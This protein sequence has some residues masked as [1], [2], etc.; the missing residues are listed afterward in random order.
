MSEPVPKD[1]VSMLARVD[2]VCRRFEAAWKAHLAEPAGAPRPRL[3]YYVGQLPESDQVPLGCEL[4]A[5][6]A[7]YARRLAGETLPPDTGPGADAIMRVRYFGDYELL[8][9]IAS[10]GFG[11]VY[12]A[13]QVTLNRLVALKMIA[14]GRLATPELVQRFRLEA[15]AA[16]GLEHEGIVP[17]YEVGA[18]D[19]QHYFSMKLIEGGSL[20]AHVERFVR[21]PRAAAALMVQVARAVHHAHQRGVLHR[22]LKP[23][24]ILLDAKGQ[25]HVTD[26]GLAKLL[27][28]GRRAT[29]EGKP[30]TIS[31]A[32]LGTPGYMAPEQARGLKGVTTAADVYGLGAVLYE[33]LTGR[34]PFRSDAPLDALVQVV[35]REPERPRSLD[36]CIDRDLETVCLKCLEKEPGR[37]YGTAEA[38]AE[39][40][41]R[42][43]DGRPILARPAGR[44]ER[45][46]RWCRRN[47]AVAALTAAVVLSLVTG[48]VLS[49]VFAM[50]AADKAEL[51]EKRESEKDAALRR[52][53]EALADGL[54]RPQGIA[55]EGVNV[56]E[57]QALTDLASLPREQ[58][59]VRLLLV[60]QALGNEI[61]AGQLRRRLE[62]ALQAAVGTVPETRRQITDFAKGAVRDEGRPLSIRFVAARILVELD[63]EEGDATQPVASV[64]LQELLTSDW[65]TDRDDALRA[66][67]QL[68]GRAAPQSASVVARQAVGLVPKSDVNQ[69][70]ALSR[71]AA[72]VAEK[73]DPETTRALSTAIARRALELIPNVAHQALEL[74][75]NDQHAGEWN[76]LSEVV[77]AVAEKGDP[78]AIRTVV[79]VF[80][81]QTLEMVMGNAVD[82]GFGRS[83]SG[84]ALAAVTGHVDLEA[85]TA[86]TRKALELVPKAKAVQL[87]ELSQ[88]MAAVAGKADPELTRLAAT[89]VVRRALELL[90]EAHEDELEDVSVVVAAVGEKGGPDAT[91]PLAAAIARRVLKLWP[92]HPRR[93]QKV[94]AVV[95]PHLDQETA[96]T[97][98]RQLIELVSKADANEL[99]SLTDAMTVAEKADPETTRAAAAAIS[100]RALDL[101]K[102]NEHLVR[103]AEWVARLDWEAAA[104]LTRQAL[105]LVPKADAD[106]LSSLSRII[107]VADRKGH[108]EAARAAAV[109]IARRARELLALKLLPGASVE[110]TPGDTWHIVY[111]L[112][113]A[114]DRVEWA[115]QPE[116]VAELGCQLLFQGDSQDNRVWDE[117]KRLPA[118]LGSLLRGASVES[119]V[120]LLKHPACVGLMREAVLRELGRQH[121]RSFRSVW[122]A[123]AWLQQHRPDIDLNSPPRLAREQSPGR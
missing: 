109:V 94:M 64:L 113:A 81:R 100:R 121:D 88:V 106:Q 45:M 37:R 91:R 108:P 53:E 13:R 62:P 105:E 111:A 79:A 48:T 82:N 70:K 69:L 50:R 101:F 16:A 89:A 52:T 104:A 115:P 54:L 51:A 8:E 35:E 84:P 33:L 10:G 56:F 73:A 102:G 49:T 97:L 27:E 38:V 103:L 31:G 17:V 98:T 6:D 119:L 11:I 29:T 83:V 19:G 114:Q 120:H 7:A 68:A 4:R 60:E 93:P 87:S 66:I 46:W 110:E 30:E 43:L 118:V 22:D 55:G 32:V 80:A 65:H 14:D 9:R 76:S 122:D 20:T 85:A 123:V 96:T 41:E 15:E 63:A 40:L 74:A 26:F 36:P 112:H 2:E 71:A 3:E 18:H 42:W 5:V 67:R 44:V 117:A 99:E 116:A 86:I 77:A 107:A 23:G 90:S 34:P 61:K 39:E 59:R 95:A 47:P 12:K 24:N 1:G 78:D 25:P 58:A 21:D 28:A 72:E 75:K 57:W 92:Q